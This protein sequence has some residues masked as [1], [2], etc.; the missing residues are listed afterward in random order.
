M[1]W[2][3][4]RGSWKCRKGL[5]YENFLQA[6][7]KNLDLIPFDQ[8]LTDFKE[9]NNWHL[10]MIPLATVKRMSWGNR[11]PAVRQGT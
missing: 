4:M 5:D 7:V 8:W 6:I 1:C 10:R 11:E 3:A 2:K 9:L